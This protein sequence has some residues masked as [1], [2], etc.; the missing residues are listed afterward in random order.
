M[1]FVQSYSGDACRE[2]VDTGKK[3]QKKKKR[4]KNLGTQRN[5]YPPTQKFFGLRWGLRNLRPL[6][7]ELWIL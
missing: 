1:Q 6:Y 4:N 5:L 2:V 7:P 3:T